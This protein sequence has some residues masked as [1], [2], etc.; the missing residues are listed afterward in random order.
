MRTTY[1]PDKPSQWSATWRRDRSKAKRNPS[2]RTRRLLV[3]SLEDRRLLTAI[4]NGDY[5]VGLGSADSNLRAFRFSDSGD[6]TDLGRT[7][8]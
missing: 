8:L 3:A 5:M 1:D 7:Q 6:M 4:N 2:Q